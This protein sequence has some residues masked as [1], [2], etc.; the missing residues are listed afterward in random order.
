MNAEWEGIE[1][2]TMTTKHPKLWKTIQVLAGLYVLLWLVLGIYGNH[3]FPH[4]PYIPTGEYQC[5]NDGRGPCGEITVED[6][7]NLD[8]P[9]WVKFLRDNDSELMLLIMMA[10]FTLALYAGSKL[11]S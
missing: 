8:V 7:R 6:T 9:D 2:H 10:M 1:Q 11:E 4:G 5:A 3:Y